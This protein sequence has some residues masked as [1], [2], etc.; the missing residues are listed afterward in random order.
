MKVAPP[1]DVGP[2]L[3]LSTGPGEQH[4]V[5]PLGRT[6]A[7][8][9][10]SRNVYVTPDEM[11][12]FRLNFLHVGAG[13]RKLRWLFCAS[14]RR[15]EPYNDSVACLSSARPVIPGN[16]KLHQRAETC[17]G[18]SKAELKTGRL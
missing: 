9:C 5:K 3:Q 12:V 13:Y 8:K 14:M 16:I 11:L 6:C 4:L 1:R 7:R 18:L 15:F 10:S 2:D 17:I